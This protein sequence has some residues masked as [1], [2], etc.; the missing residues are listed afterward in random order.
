MIYKCRCGKAHEF[1]KFETFPTSWG[2]RTSIYEY[3]CLD[4]DKHMVLLTQTYPPCI[5]RTVYPHAPSWKKYFRVDTLMSWEEFMK[6]EYV[7]TGQI[8]EAS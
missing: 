7:H 5:Y 4:I 6:C 8:T 1:R 2:G 3:C